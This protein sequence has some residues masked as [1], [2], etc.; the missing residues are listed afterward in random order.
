MTRLAR[1]PVCNTDRCIANENRVYCALNIGDA[2]IPGWLY[3]GAVKGKGFY[4]S[5][6][7]LRRD[8]AI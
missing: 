8:Y 6:Q 7:L 1:C 3:Q 5:E 4:I 2:A